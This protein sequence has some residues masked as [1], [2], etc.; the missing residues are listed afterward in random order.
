MDVL[1]LESHALPLSY[2]VSTQLIALRQLLAT[3]K[4]RRILLDGSHHKYVN[5]GLI[6]NYYPYSISF[7]HSS[8][9]FRSLRIQ[10]TGTEIIGFHLCQ[11]HVSISSYS[12]RIGAV[13]A[14]IAIMFPILSRLAT[15]WFIIVLTVPVIVLSFLVSF[16]AIHILLGHALDIRRGQFKSQAPDRPITKPL[17]FSTPAAW[18]AVIIRS[19]WSM[20]SPH[21]FPPLTPN[22]PMLSTAIN[23]ILIMIVR[24]FVLVWYKDLSPSPSFPT[25]VSSLLHDTVA[26]LVERVSSLD[27]ASLIAHRILPKITTHIEQFQTSEIA[28]RGAGLERHLT[29]SEELDLLLASR[30]AGQGG[31]LHPA[32]ENLASVVTKQTEDA[33]LR[34]LVDKALNLV[35]PPNE[36]ASKVVRIVAKEIIACAVLGSVMEMLADPY[37]WNKTIDELVSLNCHVCLSLVF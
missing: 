27:L 18:Q 19:Q 10:A 36:A 6:G 37:F 17:A 4:L 35:L 16:L 12:L 13:G 26:S 30:Y 2:E 24:D 31:K 20:Q 14:L 22:Y 33:H 15:S 3:F 7:S 25:A 5:A 29:E 23:D 11:M 28:L 8:D 1:K 21:S 34:G 9:Q 32:V